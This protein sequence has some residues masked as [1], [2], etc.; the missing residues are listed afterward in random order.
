[1]LLTILIAIP[2]VYLMD[3]NKSDSTLY[4]V[5]FAILTGVVA[6]G[7]VSVAIEMSNNFRR[8][9]QRLLVLHEYLLTL[10]NYGEDV[11]RCFHGRTDDDC[12]KGFSA[13]VMAVAELVLT[14]APVIETAYKDGK[15]YMSLEEMKYVITVIESASKIGELAESY[16]SNFMDVGNDLFKSLNEPLKSEL[17]DFADE[18]GI[19]IVN[20]EISSVIADYIL[21]YPERIDEDSMISFSMYEFTK[22]IESFD[23]GMSKLQAFVKSEPGYHEELIP[24]ETRFESN[25]RKFDKQYKKAEEKAIEIL[26]EAVKNG[27]I[28][29][30][31]FDEFLQLDEE[32]KKSDGLDL[33]AIRKRVGYDDEAFD[34]ELEEAVKRNSDKRHKKM[35][36]AMQIIAK[37]EGQNIDTNKI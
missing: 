30:A 10:A 21:T 36:R 18:V 31:E 19:S 29:Q 7:L 5:A 14:A 35:T 13:R 3:I 26:R 12:P 32:M 24:W 28:T 33:D 23:R 6:S 20:D 1:M 17:I 16:A 22:A 37:A 11:K 15:E 27:K 9:Y 25:R 34:K 4:Q 2:C 8:N